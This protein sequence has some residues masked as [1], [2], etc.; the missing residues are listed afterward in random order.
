MPEPFTFH[1]DGLKE[2]QSRLEELPKEIGE[3]VIKKT[4][5]EQ[6]NVVAK[7]FA[8]A[9]PY[10]TGFLSKH[11][12]VKI[13]MLKGYI[14]G[15]AYIGPAGK[16]DYPKHGG[17]RNKLSRKGRVY[18]VGRIAVASVARFLEFG[19]SKMAARPFMR[20]TF[21]AIRGSILGGIIADIQSALASVKRG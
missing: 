13:T 11:F 16:I 14:A 21:E 19:T 4:L 6:G 9:A 10:D 20:P 7:A 2:L 15:T 12:N 1:V 17:Y 18:K 8:A 3:K 5:S